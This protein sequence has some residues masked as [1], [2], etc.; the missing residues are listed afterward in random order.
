VPIWRNKITTRIGLNGNYN[1]SFAFVNETLN[2][3]NSIGYRPSVRFNVTLSEDFSVYA[4]ANFNIVNTTYNI[5]TSQDQ[6]TLNNSYSVEFNAKTFA[7]IYFNSNFI[8]SQFRND[9]F[10]FDQSIPILNASVYRRFLEGDKLEARVSLYD[11]FNQNLNASTFASDNSVS[12]SITRA[13]GRYVMF[14]LTYNIRGMKSDVRRG[15][16]H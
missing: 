14:S 6:R 15:G 9:R 13:I 7:G 10:G 4:N 12:S 8:Y 1:K 5:S 16:W 3:T 2:E 11:A